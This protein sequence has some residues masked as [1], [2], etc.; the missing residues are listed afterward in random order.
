MPGRS[1]DELSSFLSRL[2]GRDK[3]RVVCID[4]SS[5]YR[6][7]VRTCFPRDKIVA[8]RFHVMRIIMHHFME[9]VQCNLDIGHIICDI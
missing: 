9:L 3:V 7:M 5:P 1:E 8:D 4:L 2:K 6:R